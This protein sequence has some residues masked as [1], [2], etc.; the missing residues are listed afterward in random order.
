MIENNIQLDNSK[1]LDR[2]EN[3]PIETYDEALIELNW[4]KTPFFKAQAFGAQAN[5]E[6][7]DVLSLFTEN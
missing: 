5:I 1:P 7:I 4:M 3:Q 2:L 6:A